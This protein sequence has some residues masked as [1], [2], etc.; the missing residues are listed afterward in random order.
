MYRPYSGF[1]ELAVLQRISQMWLVWVKIY[2][3]K[4]QAVIKNTYI[5]IY[6][7]NIIR[8]VCKLVNLVLIQL[9][10]SE[11]VFHLIHSFITL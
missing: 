2:L 3:S 11:V 10:P 8:I 1:L 5:L 6:V 7:K 9:G 4:K